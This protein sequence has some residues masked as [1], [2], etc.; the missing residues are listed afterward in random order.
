MSDC[1]IQV[2]GEATGPV[3]GLLTQHMNRKVYWALGLLFVASL[4]LRFLPPVGG[5]GRIVREL[6][7]VPA[8]VALF[9]ALF[10]LTRD[11]IAHERSLMAQQLQ[12]SFSIGATSHMAIVAFD[13]HVAFSE[14]YVSAMFDILKIL[15]REGPCQKALD[16]A[17]TLLAIR[18]KYSLW[19][20]AEVETQ[21]EQFEAALRKMGA[22]AYV[23]ETAPGTSEHGNLVNQMYS[24]F[25]EVMGSKVMGSKEWRGEQITEEV[26]LYTIIH[27]LQKVLGV[28]ELTN[29]RSALVSEAFVTKRGA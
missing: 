19:I 22:A 23:V 16:G 5:P 13:R 28:E 29:L 11:T 10:Q 24:A 4:I 25:A 18:K 9:G 2:I 15:F 26:A 1:R 17:S 27:K 21:L 6:S 14:D 3:T 8:L 7:G 12:N 20:T